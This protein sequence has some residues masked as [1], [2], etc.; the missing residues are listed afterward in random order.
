MNTT[1]KYVKIRRILQ[2][3]SNEVEFAELFFGISE[4]MS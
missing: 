4:T 1:M 2:S 3:K